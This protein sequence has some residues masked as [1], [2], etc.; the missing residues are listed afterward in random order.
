V[1]LHR[2]TLTYSFPACC[3][4]CRRAEEARHAAI[5]A[6]ERRKLLEQ[7]AELHEFLPP[8]V[9]KDKQELELLRQTV[10]LKQQQ[11]SSNFQQTY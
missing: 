1:V 10:Q 4:A 2:C 8:G 3:C 11:R 9:V 6:E 5:I 7:A